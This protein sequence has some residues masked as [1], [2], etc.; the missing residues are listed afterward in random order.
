MN[1]DFN[2]PSS[3]GSIRAAFMIAVK[4]EIHE[5]IE[6]VFRVGSVLPSCKAKITARAMRQDTAIMQLRTSKTQ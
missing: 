1:D 3:T 5:L 2:I 4:M 6:M